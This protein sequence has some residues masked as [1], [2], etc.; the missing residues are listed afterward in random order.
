MCS[1]PRPRRSPMAMSKGVP[2]PEGVAIDATGAPAC[3][4]EDAA[5]GAILPI[6]G[7]EGYSFG[8]AMRLFGILA[9]G[10]AQ[11][12]NRGN[13]RFF[14]L[15]IDPTLFGPPEDFIDGSETLRQA[16]KTSRHAP[17]VDE[18]LLP[19]EGNDARCAQRLRNGIPITRATLEEI[20]DL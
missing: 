13:F 16:F 17:G 12:K 18:V 9:G 6:G 11:P 19:G 8:F 10:D 7:S 4:P 14:S 20:R 3:V 2:L 15:V 1:T 5:A